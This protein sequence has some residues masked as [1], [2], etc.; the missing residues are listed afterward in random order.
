MVICVYGAAR[1]SIDQIYKDAAYELGKRIAEHGHSLI[2]GGGATGLMGAFSQGAIEANGNVVGV[3]PN[4]M[5][6]FEPLSHFATNIIQCENL[7]QR[8]TIMEDN[9]D[10]FVITPGGIGTYDEFFQ[11]LTLKYLRRH[12]K[13]I[14][15]YNV[16]HFYDTLL[17]LIDNGVVHKVIG[18]QIYDM[19]DTV[20]TLEELEKIL[21]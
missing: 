10:A 7:S 4:F 21:F 16:H 6:E 14:I 5:G 2:Y 20:T 15:V 9:A 19:F 13:P 3:V 1:D 12:D 8:K 11:V 18:E 17:A